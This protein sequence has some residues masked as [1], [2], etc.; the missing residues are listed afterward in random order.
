ML[1]KLK[2]SPIAPLEAIENNANATVNKI[3]L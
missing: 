1:S 2:S 3:K